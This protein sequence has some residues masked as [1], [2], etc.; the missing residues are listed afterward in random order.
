MGLRHAPFVFTPEGVAMLPAVLRSE[1]AV[2]LS[3]EDAT[4]RLESQGSTQQSFTR[5]ARRH[6][7]GS[8]MV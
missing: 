3:L 8:T 4:Q 5:W 2:Q 1:R 6:I 7:L